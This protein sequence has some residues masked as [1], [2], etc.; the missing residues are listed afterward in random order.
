MMM[1]FGNLNF[2]LQAPTLTSCIFDKYRLIVVS[3]NSKQHQH[4]FENGVPI[5]LTLSLHFYLLYF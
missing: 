1:P 5:Q 3:F 2:D 4:T